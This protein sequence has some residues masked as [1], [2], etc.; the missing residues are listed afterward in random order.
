MIK[1]INPLKCVVCCLDWQTR[2]PTIHKET[3]AKSIPMIYSMSL[4][5]NKI[6]KRIKLVFC[7]KHGNNHMAYTKFVKGILYVTN[8]KTR[9]MRKASPLGVA[10]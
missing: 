9:K 8:V 5:V 10:A 1:T 3:G 6:G 7:E 4:F 2:A